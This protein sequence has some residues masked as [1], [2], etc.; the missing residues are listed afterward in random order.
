MK[1]T[2]MKSTRFTKSFTIPVVLTGKIVGSKGANI[3]TIRRAIGP[4]SF[5]RVYNS[6]TGKLEFTDQVDGN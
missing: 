2:T 6:T 1:S 5:V 3:D 4:K